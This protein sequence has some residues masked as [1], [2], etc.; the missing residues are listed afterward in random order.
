M[1]GNT[2]FYSSIDMVW[3][4]SQIYIKKTYRTYQ[5]HQYPERITTIILRR[6]EKCKENTPEMLLC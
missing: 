1:N 4:L 2:V 6:N 5:W 3:I